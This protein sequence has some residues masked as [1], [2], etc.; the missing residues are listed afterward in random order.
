NRYHELLEVMP[1]YEIK[2][3]EEIEN[4]EAR[5]LL[6]LFTKQRWGAYF[7]TLKYFESKHPK[8]KYDE[9]IKN[10]TAEAHIHLYERDRDPSDLAA[11]RSQYQYL[12]ETYPD[13]VL[14]ERNMLLLAYSSLEEKNGA[15]AIQEMTRYLAKYPNSDEVD[16]GNIALAEAYMILSKPD[17]A[18][19]TY[20]T[21]IK[22]A[23]DK[24]YAVEAD[25][26]IADVEFVKKNYQKAID[27]VE[28]V[29]K[30]YP[31]Y[32]GLLPSA[33]Y[34]MSESQ[35]WLGQYDK[36]LNNYIEFL[37]LFPKNEQSGCAIAR[38]G[39]IL[40]MYGA[41][42]EKV[43]GAFMEGYFRF[44]K[45]PGSEISRIRMLTNNLYNMNDREKKR[46]MTEIDEISKK[47]T[48]SDINEF[49]TLKKSDGLA[50]RK[51]NQ[52]SL[53]LLLDYY[54]A[55]PETNRLPIIKSRIRRN[56]AD[57]LSATID[58]KKY[59]DALSFYGKYSTTWLKNSN[60]VDTQYYNALAFE[61]A[62][63]P[64]QAQKQYTDILNYIKKIEGSSEDKMRKVYEHPVT[65]DQVNLRMAATL[66]QEK[67]Y[68]D[69]FS[70]LNEIKTV[71]SN[72]DEIEK[73]QIGAVVA[74]QMGDIKHAILYLEKLM[75]N[76]EKDTASVAKSEIELTRLYLA[77]GRLKDA[78]FHIAHIESMKDNG[79]QISD[80]LWA[81]TLELK[82]D[83]LL[84]S[85]ENLASVET[86][87]K[88]LDS[89]E[90][91]FPLSSIRYKAGKIL[92][93]MGDLKGA[94][95]IW[96]ALQSETGEIYKK[97]AL[98]KLNQAE[99]SDTYKKYIDRIPAAQGLK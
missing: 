92:F 14:T 37:R 89:Y 11:F 33:Q 88:L 54:H 24:K 4:K 80:E 64:V 71:M 21:L 35:F 29:Q 31:E 91:K 50:Q 58:E 17:D 46:A 48:L 5:F 1:K 65:T 60:R 81:K 27:Q 57:I 44:P 94:E 63:V 34:N 23:K 70:K 41:D 75:K 39:E 87:T 74:E 6:T 90:T 66:L 67:K 16:R 18:I 10:M 20:N 28:K 79:I 53:N 47:S 9:I 52:D 83:F 22:N 78:E 96:Q 82:G 85:G 72:P 8:T 95:K 69:A 12:V 40:E 56:I 2:P 45:S 76:S 15:E 19:A 3:S 77:D 99:W 30:K 13:S 51:E 7:T 73:I 68:R 26:R 86:Y 42:K 97:I 32:K 49:T 55:H 25:Y 84:R 38:V 36:S 59:V 62:G 61:K 43:S 93:D 98:E